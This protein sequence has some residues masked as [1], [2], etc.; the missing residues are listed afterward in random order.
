MIGLIQHSNNT[1]SKYTT[2]PNNKQT[3]QPTRQPATTVT[4]KQTTE[5][6]PNTI[7][8]KYRPKHH[9]SNTTKQLTNP[10]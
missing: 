3:K 10:N 9:N 1:I 8:K 7:K 5:I 6:Q 4:L 2:T